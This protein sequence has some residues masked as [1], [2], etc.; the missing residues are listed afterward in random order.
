VVAAKRLLPYRYVAV[1]AE[2]SGEYLEPSDAASDYFLRQL[3]PQNA[4]TVNGRVRYDGEWFYKTT[5]GTYVPSSEVVPLRA[6]RFAGQPLTGTW[7]LP[8]AFVL[9]SR[10]RVY[11]SPGRLA[12]AR[13]KRFER[14]AVLE[15][16]RRWGGTY[17]RIGRDR[18]L[19]R[20][21]V[22]LAT[23][24]PRPKGLA[25]RE[26]WIDIDVREQ[27]LTA[28]EG[29]RPV[30]TTLVSTGRRVRTPLGSFR[31]WAKIAATDMRSRQR[32]SYQYQMWDVP[33]TVF[34]SGAYA[35]H[36]TYWHGRFGHR[37]SSGCVNLSPRD[38]RTLF[39]FVEPKLPP[40][41]WAVL[42]RKPKQGTLVRVHD[43]KRLGARRGARRRPRAG[44]R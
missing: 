34:F 3:A 17:L 24:A 28:Y 35:L 12:R 37:K 14:F 10:A 9:R 42:P 1:R 39:S 22:R 16:R 8:V 41:W 25:A 5:R 26:R 32:D 38:A 33:W 4:I 43:G 36:G 15:R 11:R 2:G 13:V 44:R 27:V 20:Q 29:A 7:R 18:W 31:V 19:R 30:Y 21:D 23:R 40:G 6:S